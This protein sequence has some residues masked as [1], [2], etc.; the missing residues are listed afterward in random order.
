[1]EGV[2][3]PEM[4]SVSTERPVLTGWGLTQSFGERRV[5]DG[6]DL[7]L[8]H[9]EDLAM[10]GVSG[11]GKSTLLYARAGLRQP[12]AG[13]GAWAGCPDVRSLHEPHITLVR[14]AT[15][16]FVFQLPSMT[17]TGLWVR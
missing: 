6:V 4:A 9:G 10:V 8:R 7:H 16:G 14:R 17:G 12:E 11:S 3:S 5:L 1:M 15:C 2:L 13:T